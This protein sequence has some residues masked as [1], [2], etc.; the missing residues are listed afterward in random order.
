[1]NFRAAS[2][3]VAL[4]LPLVSSADPPPPEAPRKGWFGVSLE[5]A[6]DVQQKELGVPRPIPRVT[7]VFTG[8]PAETSGVQV[9]DFVVSF[10]GA[11]VQDVKDLVARVGAKAPGTEVGI[12]LR[13]A[14]AKKPT[15]LRVVLDLRPD[16][17]EMLK[18]EWVG[19]SLPGFNVTD[20][21][22]GGGDLSLGEGAETSKG[23]VLII[24]YFATWCGPCKVVM[25]Q[26]EALQK[27]YQ[28]DG[29]LVL[30]VSSEETDVLKKFLV[31]H[32]VAYPIASDAGEGIRKKL[33]VSVLPTVWLVDR[34]GVIKDVFLGSGHQ[35]ELEAAVRAS[36][37]VPEPAKL[38]L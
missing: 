27:Q 20:L 23:K 22:D 15:K 7:M 4:F 11:D 3:L 31:E 10:D 16:M 1:M 9:G 26:L 33:M 36:L 25:P 32:P 14:N 6:T 19:K 21:H 17:R 38:P 30:G 18:K 37:G 35:P 13:R 2:V 12:V 8:S 24:D 28:Q 29:L 5:A 34:N